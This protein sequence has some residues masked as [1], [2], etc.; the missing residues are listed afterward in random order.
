MSKKLESFV[1]NCNNYNDCFSKYACK[2]SNNKLHLAITVHSF[3]NNLRKCDFNN[4]K[5]WSTPSQ[6]IC[7]ILDKQI[8]LFAYFSQNIFFPI[9]CFFFSKHF[10]CLYFVE[11]TTK[12]VLF[13]IT[14]FFC[15]NNKK[16]KTI[17]YLKLCD[18]NLYYN[19]RMKQ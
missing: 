11:T 4:Q 10:F 5:Q 3:S 17:P 8:E 19:K 13:S 14:Y 6:S 16:Q 1:A 2:K 9:I 15:F 18:K 12:A 7:L